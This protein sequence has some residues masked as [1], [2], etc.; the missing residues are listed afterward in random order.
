MSKA[1][2]SHS[3]NSSLENIGNPQIVNLI[4][5]ESPFSSVVITLMTSMFALLNKQSSGQDINIE[6]ITQAL[7][8]AV[9]EERKFKAQMMENIE[10]V[11]KSLNNNESDVPNEL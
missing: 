11:I 8:Q 4:L 3:G 10:K 9:E 2:V 7:N 6:V 1:K 5:V